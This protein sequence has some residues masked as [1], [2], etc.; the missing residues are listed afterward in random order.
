MNLIFNTLYG[1]LLGGFDSG[2]PLLE[3]LVSTSAD[4]HWS[5]AVFA[6][7]C[8]LVGSLS[9]VESV[10]DSKRHIIKM[11]SDGLIL[12]KLAAEPR[13]A[14]VAHCLISIPLQ[15][16]VSTFHLIIVVVFMH[17]CVD[18]VL[19]LVVTYRRYCGS[20]RQFQSIRNIPRSGS[21][22]YNI[23]GRQQPH[24]GSDSDETDIDAAVDDYRTQVYISTVMQWN[25]SQVLNCPENDIQHPV[26][27][28]Y[29]L[30][31]A[32]VVIGVMSLA[33][34]YV[35][36]LN[37]FSISVSITC[38]V[39]FNV[40]LF[41][42]WTWPQKL[43]SSNPIFKVPCVPWIPLGSSLFHS[44]LL[45]QLPAYAWIISLFWLIAGRTYKLNKNQFIDK[46]TYDF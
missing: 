24:N 14:L 28:P 33:M 35:G 12:K 44:I 22:G 43:G 6:C 21:Q 38:F 9:L 11:S 36:D 20:S 34:R 8:I 46:C 45:F 41:V 40:V 30:L 29:L 3:I 13:L 42:L 27:T 23:L 17:L 18:S 26:K 4:P 7:C 10:Q 31:G 15:L 37:L 5:A 16:T 25:G 39:A 2:S 19:G 32:A 1:S